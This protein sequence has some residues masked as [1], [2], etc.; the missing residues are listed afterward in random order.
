MNV[1]TLLVLAASAVVPRVEISTLSGEETAGQLV[2]ISDDT[3]QINADGKTVQ[4]ASSQI[5]K[6]QFFVAGKSTKKTEPLELLLTD[7]SQFHLSQAN[8]DSRVLQVTSTLAGNLKLPRN[9][10]KSLRFAKSPTNV[11][12][13]W[14]KLVARSPRKDMIVVR[15][16]DVLDFVEG[17]IG[18]VSES[19]VNVL[20]DG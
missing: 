8:A 17:V 4:V 7:G 15:K 20:L 5:L 13:A 9:Y 11:D 18:D 10:V 6:S 12:D 14:E 2:S 1:S 16:N 19:Q 3:W